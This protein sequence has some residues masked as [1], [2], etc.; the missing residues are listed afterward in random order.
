SSSG[1]HASTSRPIV[2]SLSARNFWIRELAVAQELREMFEQEG[3]LDLCEQRIE[4]SKEVI[5]K[6]DNQ[7]ERRYFYHVQL[8]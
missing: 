4:D 1:S 3:N 5:R 8:G 2:L 7:Q 6:I